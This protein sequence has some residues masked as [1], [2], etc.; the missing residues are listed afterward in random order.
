[1]L[2]KIRLI[3]LNLVSYQMYVY[4]LSVDR[5]VPAQSF[6]DEYQKKEREKLLEFLLY[7]VYIYSEDPSG[8]PS[9]TSTV[10]YF[11]FGNQLVTRTD[12]FLTKYLVISAR[13]FRSIKRQ[14]W[15]NLQFK[16]HRRSI[17]SHLSFSPASV[18]FAT[19]NLK[20]PARKSSSSDCLSNKFKD[21][22]I[23]G[24]TSTIDDDDSGQ[25]E[26]RQQS[27]LV[28]KDEWSRELSISN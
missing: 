11:S 17:S 7:A 19:F 27:D 24:N 4:I 15:I 23:F 3:P 20:F 13:C 8:V 9:A 26:R 18:L 28:R 21:D 10:G 25:T 6:N 12:G 14:K 1:M 22:N 5:H 16:R 2:K